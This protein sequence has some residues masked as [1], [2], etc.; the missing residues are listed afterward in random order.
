MR[1]CYLKGNKVTNTK[2]L[3]QLDLLL[4]AS[5]PSSL[6]RKE[7]KDFLIKKLDRGPQVK[8]TLPTKEVL[9]LSKDQRSLGKIRKYHNSPF[10]LL[11]NIEYFSNSIGGWNT[12]LRQY[13]IK[14]RH[15]Y[16]DNSENL[17]GIRIH[18][19]KYNTLTS[20]G[21]NYLK[22][23]YRTL[24][25]S[26]INK[27]YKTYW[28]TAWIL[29]CHSWT[30]RL[31]SLNN[32]QPLWYKE[33]TSLEFTKLWKGLYQILIGKD[34]EAKVQNVW[35]ESPKGKW[36]QLG[37]PSKSWRLYFHMLNLWIS[38]LYSTKLSPSIYDGF[39][40]NRGCKSWWETVLWSP[41]LTKY[42]S[43][44]ELDFSSGFPNISLHG[45]K[46]ALLNDAMIPPNIINLILTHLHSPPNLASTY[47]TLETFIEE[48]ANKPWRESC[49]SVH[50]GIGISPILFV[51]TL[52]WTLTQLK[53]LNPNLTYKWYAD[54][55]S[56]YFNL[57]G[58]LFL[59]NLEN[60]WSTLKHLLTGKNILLSHLNNTTLFKKVGLRICPKKSRLVR[61]NH[62]WLTPYKSLGL[63]YYTD[64]KIWTQIFFLW[65]KKP[66]LMNLKGS[67][68]GRGDN[69]QKKKLGTKPSNILLKFSINNKRRLDLCNMIKN[70]RPYFGLLLSKLYN[71]SNTTTST[72]STRLRMKPKSL[73]QNLKPWQ[74]NKDLPKL[75]KFT[76]YNCSSKMN[77]LFLELQT[78][79][80]NNSLIIPT[81]NLRGLMV[82]WKS[83]K[84]SSYDQIHKD[85]YTCPCWHNCDQTQE[86]FKKYSE[87]NLSSEELTKYQNKYKQM[88]KELLSK[89]N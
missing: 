29:M 52:D 87:L 42:N 44:I 73:L 21:N 6:D 16:G 81:K 56:I 75:E 27:D 74:I 49:R 24:E 33:M 14:A 82:P 10:P 70:Y 5:F 13:G 18:L 1:N 62:I 15:K 67:T 50:M 66:I 40:F 19:L 46:Q 60:L 53:L 68:R 58:L 59:F 76:L 4:R 78:S 20:K 57:K 30:F 63:S 65:Q 22:R 88:N 26:K 38:Y 89:L 37:I 25:K 34:K 17:P 80:S 12:E 79:K 54:D 2:L 8:Y 41:L 83:I 48:E 47:P 69:P 9:I 86:Y 51:I 3:H 7:I 36:R 71:G 84:T 39:I 23:R 43:L 85:L 72:K 45:V 55:G 77:N 35:I 61:L 31:A 32:W 11:S 28:S 64:L